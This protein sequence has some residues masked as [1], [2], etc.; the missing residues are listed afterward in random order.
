MKE[1]LKSVFILLPIFICIGCQSEIGIDRDRADLERFSSS[2]IIKDY[3]TQKVA[4]ESYGGKAYCAYEVLDAEKS[5]A[6]GER[7]YLWAVCQEYYRK[8]QKLEE[9]SGS[10]IPIA[11][12][13]RTENEKI[14]VLSHQVPGN[15][16]HYVRDLEA[17]F[18]KK[19]LVLAN[20]MQNERVAKLLNAVR[21]EAGVPQ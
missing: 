18:S 20:S 9:G 8:N 16:S 21:Q 6:S 3:L 14:E 7:L 4:S 11:L 13:I 15:G 17:M 19:A 5:G 2:P 1:K 12:T 10:S